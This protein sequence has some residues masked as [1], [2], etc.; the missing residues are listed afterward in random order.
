MRVLFSSASY[1]RSSRLWTSPELRLNRL[2]LAAELTGERVDLLRHQGD[3]LGDRLVGENAFADLLD[4]ELLDL[5]RVQVA[6]LACARA[7]VV[8]GRADVV[9]VLSAL[10]PLAQVGLPARSAAQ[11]SA[12]QEPAADL[13]RPL[14]VGCPTCEGLLHAIRTSRGRRAPPTHPRLAPGQAS[15][16]PWSCG[17]RRRSR[18]TPRWSAGIGASSSAS[19]CRGW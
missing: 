4:D 15:C 8:Q 18:R 6:R 1:R 5:L 10:R 3:Q 7:L 13:G 12:Q 19:A 11:Q 14:H 9:R 16:L 2:Q 17:P